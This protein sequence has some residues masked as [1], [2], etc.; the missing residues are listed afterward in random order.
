MQ[1]DWSWARRGRR[2]APGSKEVLYD[3]CFDSTRAADRARG[4]EMKAR[5]REETTLDALDDLVEHL[6]T[7]REER[8]AV[9]TI[10]DGWQL[11]TPAVRWASPTT[12]RARDRTACA[13]PAIAARCRVRRP[14]P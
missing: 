1:A 5:W 3:Q 4:A 9:L 10:S 6:G 2:R 8:K 7:L 11:F 14:R 12:T 13:D